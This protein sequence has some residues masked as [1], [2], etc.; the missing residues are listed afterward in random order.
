M[1]ATKRY[2]NNLQ[3]RGWMRMDRTLERYILNEWDHGGDTQDAALC[4]DKGLKRPQLRTDMECMKTNLE[5]TDGLEQPKEG[6]K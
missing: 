4:Q 5:Y 1:V 6:I 3:N 2:I